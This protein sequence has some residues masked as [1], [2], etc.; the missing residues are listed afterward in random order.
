VVLE[1]HTE[2][3]FKKSQEGILSVEFHPAGFALA[4]REPDFKFQKI[5]VFHEPTP[6][7]QA[8]WL[9]NA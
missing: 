7:K 4:I 8:D 6:Q 5:N 9:G 1:F 3:L 2:C